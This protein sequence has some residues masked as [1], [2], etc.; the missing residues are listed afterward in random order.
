MLR[1]DFRRPKVSSG[2]HWPGL[3]NFPTI[4]TPQPM[5]T[6]GITDLD[7]SK[8]FV[9]AIKPEAGRRYPI[10]QAI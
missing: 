8:D 1:A 6:G 3:G 7:P 10:N 5:Y 2:N 4:H 9:H